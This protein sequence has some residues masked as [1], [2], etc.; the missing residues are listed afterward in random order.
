MRLLPPVLAQTAQRQRLKD[1][2]ERLGIEQLKLSRVSENGKSLQQLKASML[3]E[4]GRW[5]LP[6]SCT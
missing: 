4:C 3:G 6:G 5:W 1:L 2:K